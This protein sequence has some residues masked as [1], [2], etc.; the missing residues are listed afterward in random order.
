[1]LM[2]R[3]D[4]PDALLVLLLV[5][6]AYATVRAID[7]ASTRA[8]TWWLVAAGAAVGF[9]FLTKMGQALLVVPAFGLAYL[10]AGPTRLRTRLLQLLAAF[11][12]VIASAG[13][14]VALV[15]L[16][17]ADSRPYIGGSTT[18]SLLE[19]ALGYNGLG[20]I[21]GG[22]GNGGGGGAGGGNT[23]F[24]GEAGILRLFTGELALEVSWLLPAALIALVA[25]VVVTWRRPRKD[26]LRAAALL[27]GGWAL[28]T[29]LV[30]SFMSGTMHPYYTVALAPGIAALVGVGGHALWSRRSSLAARAGLV[31]MVA[32][33]AAWSFVLLVGSTESF[34]WIRWVVVGLA[35]PAVA[36]LLPGARGLARVGVVAA[37]VTG[38][39]G[40]GAYGIATASVAHIGSIPSV[41]TTS[42]QM[43]GGPGGGAPSGERPDGAG[44]GAAPADAADPPQGGGGMG[45][46]SNSELTA[47]LTATDGTWSAAVST[48]QSAA[49]LELASGTAVMSTG[50]WGGSD[51]AVTLE[52]FQAYV[53]SGQISYYVDSGQGGGPGGGDSDS[54][55]SQIAEWVA[56]NFT[57]TTV[58][59]QT[60]Y[61]LQG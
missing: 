8:S 51:S 7:A 60:V 34:A 3:F 59:G 12:S 47:L 14:F 35:V 5:T 17:P 4:N 58:G 37:L 56:A 52:Q 25:L 26:S 54:T 53:A 31:L 55:S 15:E 27:W 57:G 20:R 29:G 42:S 33:T 22:S 16:W 38:L 48:S 10:V 19:L 24:G 23:G 61:D 44:S 2:F 36:G 28:V 18:N 46:T 40:T 9:G 13:W 1:V 49:S 32:A 30:F 41:G 21:L 43:G 39:L 50:G 6:G 11:V 45:V